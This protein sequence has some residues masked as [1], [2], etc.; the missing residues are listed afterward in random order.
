MYAQTGGGIRTWVAGGAVFGFLAFQPQK[1]PLKKP[2]FKAD[3]VQ[4]DF[5]SIT[6]KLCSSIVFRCVQVHMSSNGARLRACSSPKATKIPKK[7]QKAI[8]SHKKP[9]TAT[10]SP[11]S[12]K[13]CHKKPKNSEYQQKTSKKLYRTKAL[14][15]L[16]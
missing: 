15:C 12:Q 11:K 10:K 16:L 2:L 1:Q 5:R 6:V 9:K 8:N 14:L 3:I 7:P 4:L 13:N